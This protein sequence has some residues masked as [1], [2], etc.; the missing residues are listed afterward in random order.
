M[1][2]SQGFA[3]KLDDEADATEGQGLVGIADDEVPRVKSAFDGE[4]R[5]PAETQLNLV[6]NLDEEDVQVVSV[7]SGSLP[8]QQEQP[9]PQIDFHGVGAP[10]PSHRST[11]SK[12]KAPGAA[13]QPS[14]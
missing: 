11:S 6:K 14:Q 12:L 8:P 2:S 3:Q 13:G 4:E 1:R 10:Q 5:V 7:Q 9:P